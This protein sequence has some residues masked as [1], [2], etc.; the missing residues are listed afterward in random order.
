MI[1]SLNGTMD[2]SHVRFRTLLPFEGSRLSYS[3]SGRP[4]EDRVEGEF[5]LGE[6]PG[7]TWSVTRHT[8]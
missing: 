7:A 6:Y 8:W 2:G 3:F 4:R 5:D 1:G